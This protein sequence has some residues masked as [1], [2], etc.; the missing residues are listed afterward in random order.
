MGDSSYSIQCSFIAGSDASG[1]GYVLVGVGVE[2]ITGVISQK[3]TERLQLDKLTDYSILEVFDVSKENANNSNE[4]VLTIPLNSVLKCV[5]PGG[6]T[7]T[8][9]KH[10]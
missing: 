9:L 8:Y 2:N 7:G 1:C 5:L 4:L 6:F 3:S 10:T